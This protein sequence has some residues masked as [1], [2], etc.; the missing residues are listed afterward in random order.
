MNFDNFL[1]K[2]RATAEDHP[3]PA[4]IPQAGDDLE[5]N[6]DAAIYYRPTFISY[7]C[8]FCDRCG[9]VKADVLRDY[10]LV[11]LLNQSSK[12]GWPLKA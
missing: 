4:W 1:T 2:R 12:E 9:N 8:K 6:V 3:P 7:W 5:L 10:M 11:K